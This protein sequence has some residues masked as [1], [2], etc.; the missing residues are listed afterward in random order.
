MRR[1]LVVICIIGSAGACVNLGKPEKV[2]ECAANGTCVNNTIYDG[3]RDAPAA[4][5][6]AGSTSVDAPRVDAK[7][8]ALDGSP[9]GNDAAPV[10][11]ELDAGQ[12]PDL[13]TADT[14]A[15]EDGPQP[16]V[17]VVFPDDGPTDP[18]AAPRDVAAG[19]CAPGGV[20][21]PAGTVCRPAAGPCDVDET[22]DGVTADCPADQLAAAGKECRAAA[23]DCDV[24]E[25]CSGTSPEC[26][27]DGFKQAGTVCR[28]AAGTCDYAESCTGTNAVCPTDGL[29]PSTSVCNA[30]TGA[31][32]PAENCTGLSVSCPVDILYSAP[33]A[34][35]TV[36]AQPGTLSAAI[37][38]SAVVGATAYN[39]KRGTTSGGPY[40]T[41]ATGVLA[42]QSP[43]SDTGLDSASTY[44]YVVS[45]IASIATC[46]S[47]NSAPAS[48]TPTGVCTKP[49][50][51]TVT[52]T[53]G[54]GQ[55][56]LSWAAVGGATGYAIARSDTSGTGYASIAQVSV[57]SYIDVDVVF[58]NTYYYQV[59]TKGTCDSDPST[60]VSASPLCAPA[61][62]AP[63]GLLATAPNTGGV[64]VLTWTAVSGATT[65]NTYQILRKLDSGTAYTQIDQ[66]TSPTVTYSDTTAANGSN[67]DYLV[68]FNNG[69]C[70]SP[71]SNVAT[72]T[73][74]CV[75]DKPV[76]TA[77]A[78]DRKV[79]LAWTAPANGSLTGYTISRKTTGG[80]TVIANLT[81]AGTTTYSDTNLTAGTAYTYYVTAIGNCNADSDP[82]TTTPVCTPP[83][84]PGALTA[85][86]GD[87][88]VTLS[89]GASTPAPASYTVQRKTGSAGTYATIASPT[90]NSYTD[91]TPP[92]SNGT[93][94][95]Y[96]VSASNGSC[97]SDFNA[98][99]FATPQPT[100]TQGAPGNV[101]A[102][103]SGSVQ[104]TITWTAA[105]PPPTKYNISRS[106]TL[107]G[108]YA[109][110][111]DTADG[112]VLTYI[113]I[114]TTMTPNTTYYYKVTAIGTICS[115]T[116]SAVPATTACAAPGAPGPSITA[117]T[118]GTITVSWGPVSGA[119][120][121]TV[122]RG[123]ASGGP[124]SP[125]TGATNITTPSY[126]D[127]GLTNA[128]TYY[129][130][131]TASNANHQC[132]SSQSSEVSARSCIIPAAPDN[133]VARRS[134]NKQVTLVWTNPPLANS[135]YVQR[136]DGSNVRTTSG[137]PYVDSTATNTSPFSY[138]VSAASDAGGLCSSGNSSNRPSV[139]SCI[140]R[141]GG[142]S[143]QKQADPSEW[144]IVTCDD[145]SWWGCS[146]VG[147]RTV[148]ANGAQITCAPNLAPPT[149]QNGGSAFYFTAGSTGNGDYAYWNYGP[150]ANHT[151]Q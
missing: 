9:V 15:I 90:T 110:I 47:A 55:V 120:A 22:C 123:T 88:K 99:A 134:G 101:A 139:P 2:A 54:N 83:S 18:P 4:N 17:P 136:S 122:S 75:M 98:E 86:A 107:N 23:G 131:V 29:K 49:A 28:A 41:I 57:T 12:L 67:Y 52:A 132:V 118:G 74:A 30:S 145:I 32:D 43:Y 119:T 149:K 137:S 77:T 64:V 65:S 50:A 14:P 68:T 93:T 80:Y 127:S 133:L 60:E 92:L 114:D 102:N 42:S 8:R 125:I 84:V 27:V 112:T 21:Q 6:E 61:A 105:S 53:A 72:V 143:L 73:P 62:A 78:G 85:T 148:Y 96:Q 38:W 117:S 130:V 109:S 82:K 48:A 95:Y 35:S 71:Y 40:T 7:A 151:C 97:S 46:E 34:P 63:T 66:V 126:P 100:C 39:I 104:V 1:I 44:Y 36:T 138:V 10:G 70:T 11:P 89:W 37:S 51:P 129:Y 24:A 106:T 147:T 91:D 94:Y 113:D 142:G 121:Y 81:G 87:A 16:D 19:I 33:S 146:G 56:S 45:S 5:S 150:S 116:S 124:Y 25:T 13:L 141:T 26:P 69:T 31:C 140:V 108:T 20:V 103:P 59:T 76:L 144:C 135:Y 115:A 111:K 58:G 79:D 3:G 128:T